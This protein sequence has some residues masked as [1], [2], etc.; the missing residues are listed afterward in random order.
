M[1][2]LIYAPF[3]GMILEPEGVTPYPT[4]WLE[5]NSKI[6]IDPVFVGPDYDQRYVCCKIKVTAF[7]VEALESTRNKFLQLQNKKMSVVFLCQGG[8]FR[9]GKFRYTFYPEHL[10]SRGMRWVHQLT[11]R[12]YFPQ[13]LTFIDK[14]WPSFLLSLEGA[15]KLHGDNGIGIK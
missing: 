14:G 10:Q 7:D 11:G 9:D 15:V 5:E 6:E 1:V 13:W 4:G 2:H 3:V 12:V 8:G